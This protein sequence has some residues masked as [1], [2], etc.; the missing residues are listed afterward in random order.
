MRALTD[1]FGGRLADN[2]RGR[3]TRNFRGRLTDGL[4]WLLTDAFGYDSSDALVS[5]LGIEFLD[6]FLEL[7]KICFGLKLRVVQQLD[8]LLGPGQSRFPRFQS[9]QQ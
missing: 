7:A 9:F 8:L 4:G 3:L 6:F 1:N 2:L 5:R